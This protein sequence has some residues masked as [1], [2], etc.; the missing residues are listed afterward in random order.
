MSSVEETFDGSA[1]YHTSYTYDT[2]NRPTILSYGSI[3]GE[4]SYDAY[5]RLW[6]NYL[7]HTTE[8]SDEP[9]SMVMTTY[10][11]TNPDDTH[12][13]A[14]IRTLTNSVG[15]SYDKTYTYTYDANGNILSIGDGTNTTS[16]VYDG[17]NQLKRENNPAAGKTWT[18]AYDA[19][20]NIT[21]KCEYAYT[22]GSLEGIAPLDTIAY[23]Y[24]A[25]DW[26]DLLTSY[27]GQTITGDS[28]GNMLS[29]G[30]WSYTWQHG[31][32]LASMTNGTTQLEFEYNADGLR[33]S[34]TLSNETVSDQTTLFHYNGTQLTHMTGGGDTLHFYYD[35]NGKRTT[36]DYNGATYAYLYNAQGDVVA[37]SD[38]NGTVVVEY[39]YD[40]WGNPLSVT[41]TGSSTIGQKNPFRYRGYF[42]DIETGLYYLQSRYYSPK[43]GRFV[44]ADSQ[45]NVENNLLGCNLF[46]Y[47]NNNPMQYSDPDGHL[48]FLLITAAIGALVGAVV[49]GVVAAKKGK[50]IWKGALKGA[51]IGGLVGIGAGAAAGIMFAGSAVASSV[52]VAIGVKATIATVSSAG[53]AAGMKMIADNVSQAWNNAPQVFWSGGDMA[54][55]GAKQVAS[56]IGGNTLEMTRLGMYL[57][58]ID[59]PYP[60]W[61]AASSNF[62]N[63]ASNASSSIYSIQ[64]VDGIKIQSIW[65]TIEYPLL[66]GRDIAYGVVSHD[67]AV[68]I[69]P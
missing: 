8:G 22:T 59:A 44:C 10:G 52:S 13:S 67:G 16:Y 11:Y 46:A 66:Q 57:E 5:G 38:T 37:L 27:D 30:T 15:T 32:Q 9:V 29:D 4:N 20:G 7:N 60:A 49:G 58:Q 51:G 41:G 26:P 18:F 68:Q 65:A 35:A 33:T 31:R 54:K 3:T 39:A 36:L 19:G 6:S 23:G 12:T 21:Q 17:L 2:D 42:Y 45:L 1:F 14:Q 25:E 64:N 55:N 62:A 56:G 50:N 48:P 53:A 69:M 24:T 40:A 34:K 47:C 63:I 28:I 61:Q 43:I